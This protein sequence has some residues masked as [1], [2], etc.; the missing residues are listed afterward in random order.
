[1]HVVF[2]YVPWHPLYKAFTEVVKGYGDLHVLVLCKGITVAQEHDLVMV[3]HVIVRDGDSC[4]PMND[5]NQ[6]IIAVR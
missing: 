6:P 2:T 1:M 3:R 4:G 5:I